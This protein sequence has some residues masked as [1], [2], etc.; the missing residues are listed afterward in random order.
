M[1]WVPLPLRLLSPSKYEVALEQRRRHA[2]LV[3]SFLFWAMTR[4]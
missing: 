2:A 4:G 1:S 3:T